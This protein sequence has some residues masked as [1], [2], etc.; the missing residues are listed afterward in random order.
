MLA[1]VD[2]GNDLQVYV[3]NDLQVYV[4]KRGGQLSMKQPEID[5]MLVSMCMEVRT[6]LA[7]VLLRNSGMFCCHHFS[8]FSSCATTKEKL[9]GSVNTPYID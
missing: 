9:I 4:G 1:G 7:V 2:V 3:N 8:H 6:S 5:A